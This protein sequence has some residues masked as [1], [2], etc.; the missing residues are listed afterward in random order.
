M[1]K[2]MK[3]S[4][5]IVAVLLVFNGL[6]NIFDDGT[7]MSYDITTILSGV[8]FGIVSFFFRKK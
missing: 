8:G 6:L 7:V 3:L 4:L 2:T 1:Q 5:I